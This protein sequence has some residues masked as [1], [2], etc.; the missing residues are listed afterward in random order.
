MSVSASERVNVVGCE[1]T[2]DAPCCATLEAAVAPAW[3][4]TL[5]FAA[6]ENTVGVLQRSRNAVHLRRG[7]PIVGIAWAHSLARL[8][9]LRVG[10]W[11]VETGHGHR[12]L[13]GEAGRFSKARTGVRARHVAEQ[14]PRVSYSAASS[15]KAAAGTTLEALR[16]KTAYLGNLLRTCKASHKAL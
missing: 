9:F 13:C 5:L 3:E 2:A 10:C 7:T 15:L 6:C 4:V 14:C 16:A 1:G 12:C 11:S 8:E